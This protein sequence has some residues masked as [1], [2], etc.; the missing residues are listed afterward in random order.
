MATKEA[1]SKF[2]ML[3]HEIR[4]FYSMKTWAG[5]TYISILTKN[6]TGRKITQVSFQ[7]C[8][9]NHT[10]S[11]HFSPTQYYKSRLDH[12]LAVDWPLFLI[13]ICKSLDQISAR[14]AVVLRLLVIL[15]TCPHK[16]ATVSKISTQSPPFTPMPIHCSLTVQSFDAIKHNQNYWKC[17]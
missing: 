4:Y 2:K 11:D 15:F 14:G 5:S 13:R 9:W 1:S 10:I 12:N 7:N 16:C 8:F 3:G 6:A 17:K